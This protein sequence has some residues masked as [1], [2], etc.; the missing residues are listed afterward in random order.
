[1]VDLTDQSVQRK[2][3]AFAGFFHAHEQAQ[4]LALIQILRGLNGCPSGNSS[5]WSPSTLMP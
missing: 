2:K 4:R 1:M 3:P 5:L